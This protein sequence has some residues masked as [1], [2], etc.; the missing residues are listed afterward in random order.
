VLEA[1]RTPVRPDLELVLGRAYLAAG[2]TDRAVSTLRGIYYGMPLSDQADAASDELRALAQRTK[3]TSASTEE[4]ISRANLL[5]ASKKCDL[6]IPDYKDLLKSVLP[7]E[8][9][10]IQLSLAGCYFKKHHY[11]DAKEL[12][13]KLQLSGPYA[14][15]AEQN[16]QRLY[17][18]VEMSRP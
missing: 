13:D 4:R 3:I 11:G 15:S 10:Q 12:L 16:A 17:Y 7:A 14:I 18:M 5:A 9:P 1:R 2:Q 8:A 6:A